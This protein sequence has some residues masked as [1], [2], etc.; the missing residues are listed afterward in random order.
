MASRQSPG[1]S[2]RPL[3]RWPKAYARSNRPPSP[4]DCQL[5]LIASKRSRRQLSVVAWAVSRPDIL[6][7][8]SR[9]TLTL[10]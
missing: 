4:M 3:K 10:P 9:G 8:F 5:L 2:W 1:C 6:D 7:W